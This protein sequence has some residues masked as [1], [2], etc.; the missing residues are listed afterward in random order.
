VHPGGAGQLHQDLLQ[1]ILAAGFIRIFMMARDRESLRSAFERTKRCGSGALLPYFTAGFPSLSVTADLLRRAD[2]CGVTAVEVGFP[3]SDSI[4]DGPTISSSFHKALKNGL[5]VADIFD[6]VSSVREEISIPLSAMVSFSIVEGIG[7]ASFI[8]QAVRAGF[9]ALIIPDL[10]VEEA[11][12]TADAVRRAGL[13]LVMLVAPNSSPQRCERISGLSS[14]FLYYLSVAGTTGVRD[15]LPAEL[16]DNV[17]RLRG[18]TELPICVG[19]GVGTAE[20]VREVCTVADG[21]VVGSAIV[22]R[23]TAGLERGAADREIVESVGEF[24]SALLEAASHGS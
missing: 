13:D 10:P 18:L 6:M 12:E 17:R 23:I 4:A 20:Q 19:F 1:A 21:A 16:A 3:Y 15:R 11:P 14:G 8:G 22:R 24:L 7:R 2:G 9:S 5:S